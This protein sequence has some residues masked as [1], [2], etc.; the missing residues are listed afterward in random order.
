M[1][2]IA[3]DEEFE[4]GTGRLLSRTERTVSDA[5]IERRDAPAEMRTRL[6]ILR[7]WAN[8]AQDAAALTAMT[9]AQRIARQAV[10]ETRVAAL[11]RLCMRLIWAAGED[12][13]S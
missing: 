10:I 11:S 9:A 5:E 12:D 2:E 4:A 6:P 1:P 3:F 7:T 8:D 13:G